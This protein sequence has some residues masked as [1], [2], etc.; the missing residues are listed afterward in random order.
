MVIMSKILSFILLSFFIVISLKSYSQNDCPFAPVQSKFDSLAYI[1]ANIPTDPA[2]EEGKMYLG[3]GYIHRFSN[4]IRPAFI[5][6]NRPSWAIAI[7]VA[8]N[9]ERNMIQRVEYPNMNYWMATL[10]QETEL[11]CATGLTWDDPSHA[12]YGYNPETVY[13]SQINSGCFQIEGPGSGWR[14]LQ[15]AYPNR[16]PISSNTETNSL[17]YSKLIEGVDGFEV[18]AL[19]KTFY[20]VYTAQIFNYNVGWNFYQNIDCK[21]K[22]DPYAYT[23]MTASAYNAGPNYFLNA[24]TILDDTASGCWSGLPSSVGGYG[25]DVARWV[26]VLDNNTG[27]C[28]Y[29]SG[30]SFWGWYDGEV[31]YSD[32]TQYLD[33]ISSFYTDID[34]EN[35]VTPFVEQAFTSKAD[36]LAGS[37]NFMDFGDVIDAIVLHLT[38]DRPSAFEGSPIGVNLNCSGDFL[39][40]GHINILNGTTTMCLGQSV[41]LELA[42]DAVIDSSVEYKWFRGDVLTGT[43]IDTNKQITIQPDELGT[44]L[45]SAQICNAGGDCYTLYSNS[46]GECQDS[47]NLN[48][49]NITAKECN[50]CDFSA[51]GVSSNTNCKGTPEGSIT[52]SLTNNPTNY[53]VTYIATTPIGND[54]VVFE[55]SGNTVQID[56]IRD[57]IYNFI[58]EDLN[59]TS[60]KAYTSIRV[61]YDTEINEYIKSNVVSGTDC[62]SELNAEIL[63]HPKPCLWKVRAYSDATLWEPHISAVVKTSTGKILTQKDNRF[64][65]E[66]E[67][68]PWNSYEV[69]EFR[70]SLNSGDRISIGLSAVPFPG[71]SNYY[72]YEFYVVDENGSTVHTVTVPRESASFGNDFMS[73]P[74]SVTC[75]QDFQNSYSISWSPDILDE[76]TTDFLSQ[77]NVYRDQVEKN[78]MVSAVNIE[79]SQCVLKDSVIVPGKAVCTVATEDIFSS[80]FPLS[81]FPNPS[82]DIVFI[83]FNSSREDNY[84]LEIFDVTGKLIFCDKGII[85]GNYQLDASD[86]E[87]GVYYLNLTNTKGAQKASAKIIVK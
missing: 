15:A 8:W 56:K 42:V 24:K 62:I 38:L 27:Y 19:S 40:Y 66:G 75:P 53:K 60:C 36:S 68:D 43:L 29:P 55:S 74:F 59:N 11:R 4:D 44:Q 58:V 3:Q 48:G 26:A 87:K 39:P 34:F 49:F 72:T 77:G 63:E 51:S 9:M 32:V 81:V 28:E 13:P 46:P 82:D 70:L 64:V 22:N 23:K 41:T 14:S 31:F 52:L 80:E 76:N 71:A 5:P 17:L 86:Y 45:Y 61:G 83:E 47:R 54:S 65:P 50:A 10:I 84:D 21:K 35:D 7:A 25:E 79:N 2:N 33:I 69:S 78:Y 12:P 6:S 18:S 16:F 85:S 20:D 57:G 30:S 37:I 67:W 73:E 1:S